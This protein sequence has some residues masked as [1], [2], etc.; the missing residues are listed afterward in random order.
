MTENGQSIIFKA[1]A[2]KEIRENA[3]EEIESTYNNEE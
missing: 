2:K 1:A 3:N